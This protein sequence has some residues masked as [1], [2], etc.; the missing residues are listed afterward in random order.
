MTD[1]QTVNWSLANRHDLSND[2]LR[3]AIRGTILNQPGAADVLTIRLA[4]RCVERVVN[5]LFGRYP[6]VSEHDMEVI[7]EEAA[8]DVVMQVKAGKLT[9]FTETPTGYLYTTA[10]RKIQGAARKKKGHE[11]PF[12][13]LKEQELEPHDPVDLRAMSTAAFMT[14]LAPPRA[15][16]ER[17]AMRREMMRGLGAQVGRLPRRMRQ[18]VARVREGLT[19]EQIAKELMIAESTVRSTYDDAEEQLQKWISP[20]GAVDAA[21]LKRYP[22]LAERKKEPGNNLQTELLLTFLTSLSDD[23]NRAFFLV[24]LEGKRVSEACKVMGDCRAAIEGLLAYA[25]WAM[26]R[27]G[28]LIFPRDFLKPKLLEPHPRYKDHMV[29]FTYW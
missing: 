27:K 19:N 15:R 10:E 22:D 26:F 12:S 6:H 20:D 7:V 11:V 28:G 8:E 2:A 3:A 4:R 25:Y 21:Y 18:I 13:Q 24:H 23:C 16:P 5:A 1:P 14:S 9:E 29:R 17:V